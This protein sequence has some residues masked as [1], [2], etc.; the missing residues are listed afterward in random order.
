MDDASVEA[1]R[2]RILR[3]DSTGPVRPGL[4][5]HPES[6][7]T[8]YHK[9]RPPAHRPAADPDILL[10]RWATLSG[11]LFSTGLSIAGLIW[12]ISNILQYYQGAYYSSLWSIAFICAGV[13]G[14]IFTFGLVALLN[15]KRR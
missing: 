14:Y 9:R 12:T 4:E 11:F 8:R 7:R 5:P 6:Q 3:L 2:R 15:S 10:L 13:A 1:L